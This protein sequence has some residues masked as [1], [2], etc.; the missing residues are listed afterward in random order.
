MTI[1][2][3]ASVIDFDFEVS[4]SMPNINID[5][6]SINF[7]TA[8]K[9]VFSSYP[10]A[11][12]NPD[13]DITYNCLGFDRFGNRDQGVL[14]F[15]AEISGIWLNKT[16]YT[17]SIDF[18]MVISADYISGSL[19]DADDIAFGM[20]I[21]GDF[22]LEMPKNSW[23]KWSDIG[24]LDFTIGHDNVAGER[25]M[26]WT[27]PVYDIIKLNAGVIVYGSNG[28][29]MMTPKDNIYGYTTLLSIGTLGRHAQI[30]TNTMHWF[31]TNEGELYE[32]SDSLKKIGYSE[33]LSD[34]S[35]IVL[36]HDEENNL[37]YLCDGTSGYVYN[38][39]TKSMGAGPVNIT[40]FG[41]K[42][43]TNYITSPEAII[44]PTIEF[45]TNTYDMGT[46]KEKT[47]FNLEIS[48]E[49]AQTMSCAVQ[50][51]V[52]HTAAWVT[53]PWVNFT[54]RGIAYLPC[55]GIEFR[56]KFKMAT[57]ADFSID[58]LKVNGI[59]HGF[60]FLDT[61]RKEN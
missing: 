10:T 43:G 12:R 14:K 53:S 31:V 42:T 20:S 55:Y 37:L 47:I 35:G 44:I 17:N 38:Y 48:T 40:G 5:A 39:I 2:I 34:M 52:N 23:V 3:N 61:V 7:G 41:R 16:I 11:D 24:S 51:R 21:S 30:G 56:F 4:G 6:D 19:I 26:E 15:D 33:F 22:I 57:W 36:T 25:P 50:Y 9:G 1:D 29:A 49:V 32:L 27:G 28:I 18:D 8:I 59:I 60:S 46:R 45:T 58:Q 13:L 54:S